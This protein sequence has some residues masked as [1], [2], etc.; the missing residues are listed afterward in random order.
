MKRCSLLIL[1]ACCFAAFAFVA[2]AETVEQCLNNCP[3]GRS[4]CSQCCMSQFNASAEPCFENCR[5]SQNDCF[6]AAARSCRGGSANCFEKTALPCLNALYH[7]MNVC[8]NNAQIAG[9]CPGEKPPRR[10]AVVAPA[11][12]AGV[13]VTPCHFDCQK[14]DRATKTC[15]GPER[16]GCEEDAA[17]AKEAAAKAA[18]ATKQLRSKKK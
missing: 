17:M 15:V 11:N 6:N 5:A 18:E 1:L 3:P 10:A 8:R 9:G 12:A 4:S 2:A 13:G 7:C 14:Y 16:N